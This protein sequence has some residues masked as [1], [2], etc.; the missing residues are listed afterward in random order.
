MKEV[1]VNTARPYRVLIGSGAV[2]ALPSELNTLTSA[3]RVMIVTD[4]SVAPLH[5]SAV[6]NLLS[7]W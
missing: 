2:S 7:P 6:Q 3:H 5:L 1:C 4:E